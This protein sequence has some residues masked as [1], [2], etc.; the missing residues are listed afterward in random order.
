MRRRA[1]T[2]RTA[3]H[4]PARSLPVT[5]EASGLP[6][7][8]EGLSPGGPDF[9]GT[10]ARPELAVTSHVREEEYDLFPGLAA[11]LS[12]EKL[13]ESGRKARLFRRR[14]AVRR[15]AWSTGEKP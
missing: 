11:A 5:P 10:P 9:D 15:A 13:P 2:C 6:R 4:R 14:P 1:T 7:H 3:G 12:P 8:P